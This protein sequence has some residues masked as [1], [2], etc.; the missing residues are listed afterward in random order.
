MSLYVIKSQDYYKEP[1]IISSD[2]TFDDARLKRRLCQSMSDPGYPED[3][4][5]LVEEDG[6]EAEI[7]IFQ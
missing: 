1:H 7:A 3:M 6:E 5:P 4:K 2:G